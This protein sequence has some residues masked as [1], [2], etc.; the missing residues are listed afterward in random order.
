MTQISVARLSGT[1]PLSVLLS[2]HGITTKPPSDT[3]KQH[4]LFSRINP[5]LLPATFRSSGWSSMAVQT[6][7]LADETAMSSAAASKVRHPT[8][9]MGQ[10]AQRGARPNA[11]EL[12]RKAT[13]PQPLLRTQMS[14][15]SFTLFGPRRRTRSVVGLISTPTFIHGWQKMRLP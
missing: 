15:V 8:P 1:P 2:K 13:Y 3:G 10:M 12:V 5:G 4:W 6:T 9:N 11:S 7:L 14:E